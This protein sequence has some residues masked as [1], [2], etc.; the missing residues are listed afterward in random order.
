[1]NTQLTPYNSI[2][3][4]TY[5]G[6]KEVTNRNGVTGMQDKPVTATFRIGQKVVSTWDYHHH[7]NHWNVYTSRVVVLGVLPTLPSQIGMQYPPRYLKVF[8]NVRG[9]VTVN[10]NS[11]THLPPIH[12][13]D[14]YPNEEQREIQA[15]QVKDGLFRNCE[16]L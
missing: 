6:K 9:V 3:T 15:I 8:C 4:L 11:V 14:W 1:M 16:N 5:L 10:A 7:M 2:F 12:D 13:N